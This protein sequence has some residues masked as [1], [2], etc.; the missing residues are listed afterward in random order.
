MSYIRPN[1]FSTWSGTKVQLWKWLENNISKNQDKF[2]LNQTELAEKFGVSRTTIIN[3]LKTF[4]KG[5]LIEKVDSSRGRGNHSTYRMKWT[6][7]EKGSKNVTPSRVNKVTPK[8]IL[9][10]GAKHYR[11]FAY[12]FRSYVEDSS[13]KQ[14]S[15]VVVG[16]LLNYLEGKHKDIAESVRIFFKRWLEEEKKDLRDFFVYFHET[17]TSIAKDKEKKHRDQKKI[18]E[19]IQRKKEIRKEYENN[20]QP[21]RKDYPS[22]QRYIEALEEWE[23]NREVSTPEAT[24]PIAP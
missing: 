9:T 19:Q 14:H 18:E 22:M 23:E 4:I 5:N 24:Q 6:F 10:K 21:R 12:K 11:Y 13:L 20:N 15:N 2:E 7:K 1:I 8:R 3:A 16:R 17:I